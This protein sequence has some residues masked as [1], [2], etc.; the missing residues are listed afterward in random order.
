VW[1]TD[2]AAAVDAMEAAK[3]HEE[4]QEAARAVANELIRNDRIHGWDVEMLMTHPKVIAEAKRR[5]KADKG[6]SNRF[7]LLKL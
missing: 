5:L 4:L 6:V 1:D 7:T 2:H 3:K